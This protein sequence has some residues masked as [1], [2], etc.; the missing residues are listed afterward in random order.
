MAFMT[1]IPLS[2]ILYTMFLY[3]RILAKWEVFLF[4]FN[5]DSL[6]PCI[7]RL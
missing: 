7:V 6:T 3:F 1:K 4:I 5:E 2:V